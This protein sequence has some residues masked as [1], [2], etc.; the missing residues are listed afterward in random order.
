MAQPGA[1]I[2]VVGAEALADQL[3]KKIGLLIGSLGR[4]EA[5]DRPPALAL[6]DS[7]QSKS[8][9]GEGL[10]PARLAEVL[11]HVLAPELHIGV[12]A[13][14]IAAQERPHQAIGMVHVV[15]PEPAL[16]TKAVGDGRAIAAIDVEDLLVLDVH[17][18]LA[19]NT[20]VG[21]ERVDGARL[22]IDAPAGT[23]EQAL[24][25]QR[26]RWTHLHALT[27][28]DAGRATH[29]L[30]EVEHHLGTVATIGH[31]NDVVG[32]HLAAGAH[33]Q[34]AVDARIEMHGDGGM[35]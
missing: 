17:L 2:D 5:G 28:G 26:A 31:A 18:G 35:R 1:V 34:A 21:A 10:L 19:A 27:A 8:R 22:V 23:I 15:E 4:A 33:A 12:F 6:V 30:V 29:A 3:L 11:Q 7:L 13:D 14:A 24:L 16:D 9:L 32:L 25:H 20:A